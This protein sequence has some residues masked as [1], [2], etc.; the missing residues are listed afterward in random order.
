MKP[1][2]KHSLAACR[3]ENLISKRFEKDALKITDARILAKIRR[4]LENAKSVNLISEI[5]G[6]EEMTGHLTTTG[7]NLITVT[8]VLKSLEAKGCRPTVLVTQ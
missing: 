3:N 7:L 1:K 5:A 8:A 4:V 6:I 2:A